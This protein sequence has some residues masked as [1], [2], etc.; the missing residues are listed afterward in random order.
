[1]LRFLGPAAQNIGISVMKVAESLW[2]G[3]GEYH[4]ECVVWFLLLLFAPRLG[5]RYSRH[6]HAS[7]EVHDRIRGA[8]VVR[9][10]DAVRWVLSVRRNVK[11]LLPAQ[12]VEM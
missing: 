1:M 7:V 11:V 2:R 6:A 12:K 5:L 9:G 3:G 8:Q 10:L 4:H